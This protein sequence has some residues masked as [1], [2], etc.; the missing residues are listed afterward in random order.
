[1]QDVFKV[2]VDKDGRAVRQTIEKERGAAGTHV[3]DAFSRLMPGHN[4]K[5]KLPSGD[6]E[7]RAG[8]FS[9]AVER[10]DVFLVEAAWNEEYLLECESFP[11]GKHDDMVDASSGAFEALTGKRGGLVSW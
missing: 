4:V 2:T 7:V 9:A 5:G 3:V 10:H 11:Y 1:V 8:P 6:K